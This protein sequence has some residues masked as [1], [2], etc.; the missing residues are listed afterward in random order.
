MSAVRAIAHVLHVNGSDVALL[1]I[2]SVA[3][4][5]LIAATVASDAFLVLLT[6]IKTFGLVIQAKRL[7]IQTP[8]AQVLFRDGKFAD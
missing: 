7:G 3:S 8:I 6:W 2:C 1:S 4:V 5:S